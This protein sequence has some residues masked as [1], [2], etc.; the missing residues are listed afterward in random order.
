V[1]IATPAASHYPLAKQA[2][3]AGK[4][5]LVEKPLALEVAEGQE[6]ETLA[7][8]QV[9]ILMV[10]HILH[11]HPAVPRRAKAAGCVPVASS[12]MPDWSVRPADSALQEMG[13][14]CT[15]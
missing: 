10:G 14:R 11:Y 6:L 4:D 8:Q 1:A 5:D 15:R 9:R 2:L 3:L 12:S 7:A 13:T